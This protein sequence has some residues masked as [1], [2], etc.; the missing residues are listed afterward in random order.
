MCLDDGQRRDGWVPSAKR[1]PTLVR[2]AGAGGE[3]SLELLNVQDDL[4][5]GTSAGCV[6][7][8]RAEV[9]SDGPPS[10]GRSG[11]IGRRFG[12]AMQGDQRSLH[13][14]G[15]ELAIDD[16][17]TGYSSLAYLANL[18]LN[19]VKIDRS[20]ITGILNNER[21][22][23]IVEAIIRLS[24]VLQLQVVAEGVEN[25]ATLNKLRDLNCDLAQGHHL[26]KPL[27]ASELIHWITQHQQL[28]NKAA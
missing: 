7:R 27:P 10:V 9:Q 13:G 24:N 17:G 1:P 16:F 8:E 18:P 26:S 14:L 19:Q 12:K 25:T 22:A 6:A 15:I 2:R 28:I 21:D 23:A 20:F 4:Q 5:A 11:T 3:G